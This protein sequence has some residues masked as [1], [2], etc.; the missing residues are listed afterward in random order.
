MLK[1]CGDFLFNPEDIS[2]ISITR[3]P[4]IEKDREFFER[5]GQG[6][7]VFMFKNGKGNSVYDY[8]KG[9][10]ELLEFCMSDVLTG[11][12]VE[13]HIPPTSSGTRKD[14]E[15]GEEASD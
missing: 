3:T 7:I 11:V 10:D 12:E 1:R 4:D 14:P 9:F 13:M 2:F 6:A 15:Y 5:T 8:E